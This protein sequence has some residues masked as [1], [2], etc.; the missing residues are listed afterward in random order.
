MTI[1][2]KITKIALKLAYLW[3]KVVGRYREISK[4][5]PSTISGSKIVKQSNQHKKP[6]NLDR[7]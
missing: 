2:T 5:K 1:R 4:S 7:I 3:G 6:I